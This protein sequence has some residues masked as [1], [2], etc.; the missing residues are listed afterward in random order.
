MSTL[1]SHTDPVNSQRRNFRGISRERSGPKHIKGKL[2]VE[3]I[4]P[5]RDVMFERGDKERANGCNRGHPLEGDPHICLVLVHS[6]GDWIGSGHLHW[7]RIQQAMHAYVEK[8]K[9]HTWV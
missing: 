4:F 5:G 9:M 1:H 8:K 6:D 7:N 2:S 3:Q